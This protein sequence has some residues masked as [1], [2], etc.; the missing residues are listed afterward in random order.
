MQPGQAFF[1]EYVPRRLKSGGV[2]ERADMKMHFRRAFTFARQGG[3]AFG[4]EAAQPTGRGVEFR[5]L[6]FGH[7]VC[8]MPEPDEHGDRGAA[9]PAAALAVAPRH[10]RWLPGCDKAHRTA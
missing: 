3:A 6:P 8:V 1:R 5:N 7:F 10:P 2:I 9:M 4:A